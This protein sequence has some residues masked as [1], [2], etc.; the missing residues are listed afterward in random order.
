M[1]SESVRIINASRPFCSTF[2]GWKD[3]FCR[4]SNFP[5]RVQKNV[6]PFLNRR[7]Q[8]PSWPSPGTTREILNLR[9]CR[10]QRPVVNKVSKEV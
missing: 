7:S 6:E 10:N 3:K 1:N 2:E 4:I 5:V 9:K 8:L